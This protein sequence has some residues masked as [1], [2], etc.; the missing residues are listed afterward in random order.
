[1]RE[2]TDI[3]PGNFTTQSVH[4]A[5]IILAERI[6]VDGVDASA[7]PVVSRPGE[8]HPSG[9]SSSSLPL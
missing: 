4:A 5:Q 8:I 2:Q 3:S 1:M 9:S 6:C 7:P